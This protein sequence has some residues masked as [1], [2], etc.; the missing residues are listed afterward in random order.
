MKRKR[1]YSWI[2]IVALLF[3]AC[4]KEN[5]PVTQLKDALLND[6]YVGV[7][8]NSWQTKGSDSLTNSVITGHF[9]SIVAE[10]CMKSESIQ[11]EEGVFTFNDADNFVSYGEANGMFIIGHCLV[12]HSQAPKWFFSDENGE[13]VSREVMIQRLKTHIDTL[14]GRYK[15]KVHGWDVVNE[16]FNEDGT[17][18]NS[19]FLQI[20]GEDYLQLAFEFAHQADPEAEL[21][22]ND[23]NMFK[24]EKCQGVVKLVKSLQEKGVKIDGVGFQGHIGLTEPTIEEYE[25]SI[26]AIA[27]LGVNVMFTELDI[28]VLPWPSDQVTA[29]ISTNYELKNEY[30]PYPNGLSDSLSQALDKRYESMFNMFNIV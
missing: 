26:N 9:N 5:K 19:K 16:A 28:T 2:I 18:R 8:L 3:S 1:N 20:I 30:N 7:A 13:D 25:T 23:Y 6:F 24:P 29:E 21:Y 15:G 11:P 10:N 17:L 22:Y 14:V 4:A 27:E 12:W